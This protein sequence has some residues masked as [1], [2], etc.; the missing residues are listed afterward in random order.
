[1]QELK[2]FKMYPNVKDLCFATPQS[3]CLDVCAFFGHTDVQFVTT[4]TRDNVK[5]GFLAIRDNPMNNHETFN[6]LPGDRA[7]IPTGIIL[8]IPEGYSVRV[9]CRSSVA[10]K[11]GLTLS[12]NEGIIDSDYVEQLYI[13]VTNTS[14]DT[15]KI[16]S[17]D[18]IA[19]IEL[20]P[21]LDYKI[22]TI[23]ARP[24]QK[25]SR[26]GGFGSTGVR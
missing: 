2:Y 22:S 7:L 18:R 4:Y 12:N 3:A 6:I 11:Q 10:L 15:V 1:M 5:T 25:T 23:D 16:N 17:G 8:D 20:I 9:H 19:Q 13:M 21:K 26:N 24:G 14:N